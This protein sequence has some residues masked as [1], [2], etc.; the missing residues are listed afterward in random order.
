MLGDLGELIKRCKKI[1]E[2]EA[3]KILKHILNGFKE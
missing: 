2:I 1:P 3:I